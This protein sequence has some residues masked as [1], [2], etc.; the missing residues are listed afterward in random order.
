MITQS[1]TELEGHPMTGLFNHSTDQGLLTFSRNVWGWFLVHTEV[2]KYAKW[3]AVSVFR[4]FLTRYFG[5]CQIAPKVPSIL[6]AIETVYL[7]FWNLMIYLQTFS[8]SNVTFLSCHNWDFRKCP[9]N[10]RRLPMIFQRLSNI[11]GN[12][13]RCSDDL[14][15]LSKLF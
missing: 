5:I 12:V 8:E 13:R 7:T 10:F 4:R 1:M 15:V 14:W 6:R 2:N 11:T 9:S 3:N